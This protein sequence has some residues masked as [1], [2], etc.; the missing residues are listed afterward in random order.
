MPSA[1]GEARRIVAVV[2]VG[3]KAVDVARVDPGVLTGRE[4]RLQA[5]HELRLRRL[6][7]TVVGRLANSGDGDLAA[8]TSFGHARITSRAIRS[9]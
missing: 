4:D 7:V 1:V 9:S 5:Q 6:A 2:A 3:G 8:Q